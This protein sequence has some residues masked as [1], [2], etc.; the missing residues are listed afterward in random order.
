MIHVAD[1]YLNTR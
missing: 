1:L